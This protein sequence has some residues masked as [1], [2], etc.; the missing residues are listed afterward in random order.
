MHSMKTVTQNGSE[1]KL[2]LSPNLAELTI[3]EKSKLSKEGLDS[4]SRLEIFVLHA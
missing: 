2:C 4:S 1:S 3:I